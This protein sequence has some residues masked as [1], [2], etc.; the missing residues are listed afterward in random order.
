M[1]DNIEFSINEKMKIFE[2]IEKFNQSFPF[3]KINFFANPFSNNSSNKRNLIVYGDKT[4]GECRTIQ[5][6]GDIC[7]TPQMTVSDLDLQFNDIY[8]LDVQVYRKSGK[9]WLETSK[10]NSWTLEEQNKQGQTLST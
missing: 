8:G 9:M 2:L 5:K 4:L 1:S 7:I 6:K 3:L 10:T